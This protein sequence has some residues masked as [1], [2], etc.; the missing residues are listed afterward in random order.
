MSGS[1]E[2][3]E[4][5]FTLLELLIAMS[6]LGF[7]TVLLFNGLSFGTQVWQ[8]TDSVSEQTN[9]LRNVQAE[10]S[11]DL[12]H[13]YP[14]MIA[15][16]TK[17][18]VDFEGYAESL[19]YLTPS[20]EKP[21]GLLRVTLKTTPKDKEKIL[22]RESQLELALPHVPPKQQSL[23]SGIKSLEFAYYGAITRDDA[24]SWHKT[25]VHHTRLPQLIRLRLAFEDVRA[26]KWPELVIAPRI[27]ADIGCT[28]DFLT[29]DCQ[30]R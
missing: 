24:P 8:R 23:L 10:L 28:F 25:W 22:I 26:P 4:S 20:H 1:R 21:G 9:R 7:L 30:G 18:H 19:S 5:G 6:L 17:P 2:E 12:T 14:M 16:P 3:R 29:K 27:M 11:R 13:A 15:D